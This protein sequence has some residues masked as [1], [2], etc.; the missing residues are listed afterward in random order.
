MT[1]I[2]FKLY[3]F[4]I[5][6]EELDKILVKGT[7]A[8]SLT[9]LFSGKDINIK[10]INALR[11]VMFSNLP[12]YAF[13]KE[14]INIEAN[15]TAAFNNDYMRLRLAFVPI[16][17]MDTKLCYL[18]DKYWNGV[19]YS[20]TTREKHPNEQSIEMYINVHNNSG[21]ITNVTTDDLTVYLDGQQIYPYDNDAPILLIKLRPNDTFKCHM[22]GVIGTS[23]TDARWRLVRN[24]WYVETDD[25]VPKFKMTI[26]GSNQVDEYIV[27]TKACGYLIK[28]L[29]IIKHELTTKMR[30]KELGGQNPIK[31]KLDGEDHT[32]GE[33]I[34]YELQSHSDVLFS[35]VTK[36]DHLIKAITLTIKTTK[37][38]PLDA[39]LLC[40]DELIKKY[41]HLGKMID[42]MA[43]VKTNKKK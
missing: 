2:S 1:D 24:V 9:V 30:E 23:E 43:K 7:K 3:K 25:K 41:N 21:S 13:P 26:E 10:M 16:L 31:L 12:T 29:E 8:S 18:P 42:D 20:D 17:N 35:G 37:S 14:L 4:D 34:N 33:I 19:N 28:K 6:V 11:R 27:L 32:I 38:E 22:R 39:V 40:I 15:T 5:L 36:T